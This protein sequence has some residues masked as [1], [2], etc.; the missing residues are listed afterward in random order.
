MVHSIF[1]IF[2]CGCDY[3]CSQKTLGGYR[4]V[5]WP[6]YHNIHWQAVAYAIEEA[7]SWGA[8][9]L[10][11]N[12]KLGREVSLAGDVLQGG[13]NLPNDVV[14]RSLGLDIHKILK[15]LEAFRPLAPSQR[16]TDRNPLWQRT[17]LSETIGFARTGIQ[18]PCERNSARLANL[19]PVN[20]SY[21]RFS[22]PV[23]LANFAS[24]N[25][26]FH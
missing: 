10:G 6:G 2:K 25:H 21:Y 3:G 18:M 17:G 16:R 15:I 26:Q 12:L 23:G 22:P 1:F 19:E 5:R 20:R 11:L 14:L 7:N 4:D 24:G 9:S 13:F 8:W